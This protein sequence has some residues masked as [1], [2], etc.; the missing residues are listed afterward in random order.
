M[1][2]PPLIFLGYLRLWVNRKYYHHVIDSVHHIHPT[3]IE[4]YWSFR[5]IIMQLSIIIKCVQYCEYYNQ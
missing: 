3:K 5:Y 1:L 4:V 2:M